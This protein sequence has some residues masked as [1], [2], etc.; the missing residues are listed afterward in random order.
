MSLRSCLETEIYVLRADGP[1]P[2]SIPEEKSASRG[3]ITSVKYSDSEETSIT[4]GDGGGG[5][6]G[7]SLISVSRLIVGGGGLS[8]DSGMISSGCG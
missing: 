5:L 4:L 6:S 1:R 3:G 8:G 2:A 7:E